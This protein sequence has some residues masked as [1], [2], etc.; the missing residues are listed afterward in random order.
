MVP[1]PAGMPPLCAEEEFEDVVAT[2]VAESAPR[3]FAVVQEYGTRVGVQ[4]AGW[5]LAHEDHV[6]V[7]G[8]ESDVHLG[9]PRPEDVLRGFGVRDRITARI[10]WHDPAAATPDDA[11][12]S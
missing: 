11:D 12:G 8:M 10:V 7:I 3:L 6:D 2:V 9:A 1:D 5:G 4:V